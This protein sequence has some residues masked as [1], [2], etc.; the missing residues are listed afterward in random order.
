MKL[1]RTIASMI[2]LAVGILAGCSWLDSV[3][4]D[5]PV[6]QNQPP[7][8]N[9]GA[10]HSPNGIEQHAPYEWDIYGNG[11]DPDGEIVEW[12]IRVNGETF[13]V[14]NHPDT[15]GRPEQSEFIRYQFPGPGW[16]TL[17]VTAIDDEGASTNYTVPPDGLWHIK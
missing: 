3:G 1:K 13:R 14:G 6:V 12:I 7:I 2:I 9:F 17:S 5:I 8:I 10:L 11:F 15:I 16:Y 4:P